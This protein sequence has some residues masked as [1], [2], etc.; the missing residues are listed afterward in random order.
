MELSLQ[1]VQDQSFSDL[2]RAIFDIIKATLQYPAEPQA[3]AI[4]LAND[5]KFFYE[6]SHQT[7]DT[8]DWETWW[9][10]LDVVCCIPP[11]HPWQDS[12]VQSLD[13][14]RQRDGSDSNDDPVRDM[15]PDLPFHTQLMML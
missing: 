8:V 10:V 15:Y 5:V 14:L 3:K 1:Y 4:K 6:A 12:L 11:D 2:G 7:T 13:I 9:V